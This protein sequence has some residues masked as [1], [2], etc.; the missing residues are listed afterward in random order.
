MES[1]S[2]RRAV[3]WLIVWVIPFL[4]FACSK[5]KVIR[6][7]PPR[8][9]AVEAMF[10]LS[11][12]QGNPVCMTVDIN[13]RRSSSLF[14]APKTKWTLNAWLAAPGTVTYLGPQK[15]K[16]KHGVLA[17]VSRTKDELLF[18]TDKEEFL[19]Y[20]PT[21]AGKLLLYSDPIFADR[22][23]GTQ[24]VEVRYGRMPAK[25][26]CNNRTVEGKLFYQRWA[27]IDP[28]R[29]G[30][31]G[32]FAGVEAGGR[33]Y[34]VWGPGGE[35]L[36]LEKGAEGGQGGRAQFAVMQDRRGRWQETY[37]LRWV[38]P[39]C[40]FSPEPCTGE[41]HAFHLSIPAWDVEGSLERL[42]Q[43][44][45]PTQA[46]AEQGAV[47]G[48]AIPE[49]GSPEGAT[50]EDAPP[51]GMPQGADPLPQDTF[52]TSLR[53]IPQAKGK[54]GGLVELCLLKGNIWVEGSQRAVYG[55]GLLVK[56][57]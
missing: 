50:P 9:A 10:F 2:R 52:W 42:E 28:P 4:L 45:V 56:A 3:R 27:W 37:K 13:K 46:A 11:A 26:F 54:E 17:P 47:A 32:P 18:T 16:S 48:A 43:V 15:G 20:L 19:Y 1:G 55:M 33:I 29:E 5:K 34:T 44:L 31:K 14:S 35:F 36:Y 30:R 12:V 51:E 6:E 49:H 24:D 7:D 38:E 41:S 39:P 40:A 21:D 23:R 8:A 57:P 25:L 53:A 22:V